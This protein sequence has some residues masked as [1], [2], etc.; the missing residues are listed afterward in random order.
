M[1]LRTLCQA[2][3]GSRLLSRALYHYPLLRRFQYL[4]FRDTLSAPLKVKVSPSASQGCHWLDRL[5]HGPACS[6]SELPD[7]SLGCR[8][9]IIRF[10]YL[11]LFKTWLRYAQRG[12][13]PLFLLGCLVDLIRDLESHLHQTSFSVGYAIQD[14]LL[15]NSMC[16]VR[17]HVSA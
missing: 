7:R 11:H 5:G 1:T 4:R 17:R 2:A 9:A 8:C 12:N 10:E 16:L 15:L 3:V 6:A 14:D 13:S